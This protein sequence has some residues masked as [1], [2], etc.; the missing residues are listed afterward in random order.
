MLKIA[1]R[2]AC[3][4]SARVR[5]RGAQDL[6]GQD[7]LRVSSGVEETRMRSEIR[8]L[9]RGRPVRLTESAPTLT[10][11]DYLRL[12]EHAV[13]PQDSCA[14]GDC[15]A[16][17]VVLRKRVDGRLRYET[18][19]ACSLLAG[20]A[21]GAEVITVED[22]ANGAGLHPVQQELAV[23][24]GSECGAC[25]TG[26]VMALFALYHTRPEDRLDRRRLTDW[27]T[28]DPRPCTSYR[29]TV[30][31][32]LASGGAPAADRFTAQEGEVMKALGALADNDDLFVG[33]DE[34][35][36]AA[37]A[38]LESL[39]AVYGAHPDAVLVAGATD[40]GLRIARTLPDLPQI[41]WLGRVRGLDTIA[42]AADAVTF[43][44]MVSHEAA[45]SHFA[46]IDPGL[47]ELM[48][49]FAGRQVRTAGTIGGT[50]AHGSP[51]SDTPPALI[52]LGA[53]LTLQ[54]GAIQRRV[55]LE[56]FFLAY[57]RQDRA[58]AE[59]VRSVRVPK[60][61]ANERFRCYRISKRLDRNISPVTGAFKF[62]VAGANVESARIAFGGM[63]LTPKRARR[64]E[65]ALAGAD[66][67][68]EDSW[69]P[70]MAALDQD[71]TPITDQLAS[72][73]FRREIS[74]ALLR[75]ALIEAGGTPT[76]DTR[77]IEIRETADA[78]A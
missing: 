51:L 52:A 21:D 58:A 65:A 17:A 53:T 22:L 10:L 1:G 35:F 57:G 30:A 55:A 31:A 61:K 37:P 75:K 42:D 24:H 63:A 68:N 36:F 49:R 9:R 44:A 32:A 64:A 48:Q 16:C 39:A 33:N 59:F 28:G 66:L 20:Q 5:N 12:S 70:A 7:D 3:F 38:S 45:L 34:H 41:I 76:R 25:G 11:L 71:F 19:N 62:V 54:K 43:G 74:H 69:P 40:V 60:L 78:S 23:R 14:G 13:G 6:D 72:A 56:D 67:T 8:F 15:G 77:V 47:G 73:A 27:I 26:V 50:L 18:V 29:P 4:C 46:A 2:S